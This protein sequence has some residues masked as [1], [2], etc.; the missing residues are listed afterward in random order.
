MILMRLTLKAVPRFG[1]PPEKMEEAARS[2]IQNHHDYGKL[3]EHLIIAMNIAGSPVTVLNQPGG[4]Y[5]LNFV[6]EEIPDWKS[7]YI[8][9]GSFYPTSKPKFKK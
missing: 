6:V 4:K 8:Y 9:S 7:R 1:M 5:D 3:A 2:F